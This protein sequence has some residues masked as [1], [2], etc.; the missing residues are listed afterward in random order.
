MPYIFTNYEAN[1]IDHS[2]LGYLGMTRSK[3]FE[4]HERVKTMVET[5]L[6]SDKKSMKNGTKKVLLSFSNPPFF[7]PL[8]KTT[9]T[10]YGDMLASY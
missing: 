3:D 2:L 4:S 7:F 9:T 5:Y 1:I 6:L 10:Y 8:R